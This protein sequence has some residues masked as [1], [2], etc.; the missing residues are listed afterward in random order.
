MEKICSNIFSKYIHCIKKPLWRGI[1]YQFKQFMHTFDNKIELGFANRKKVGNIFFCAAVGMRTVQSRIQ[2]ETW[3]IS[4]SAIQSLARSLYLYPSLHEN[5]T[6]MMQTFDFWR[7]LVKHGFDGTF[8]STIKDDTDEI[9]SEVG[10]DWLTVRVEEL[11]IYK[12]GF[13]SLNRSK[14]HAYVNCGM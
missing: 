11:F 1:F 5:G 9:Q 4:T 7:R 10:D 2:V 6:W 3:F 8:S 13:I 14:K 12:F